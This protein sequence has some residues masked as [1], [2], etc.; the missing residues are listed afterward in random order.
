[1]NEFGDTAVSKF[2]MKFFWPVCS[3]VCFCDQDIEGMHLA[4][5]IVY[6]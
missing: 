2:S 6:M 3:G 1:M 5:S 4:F